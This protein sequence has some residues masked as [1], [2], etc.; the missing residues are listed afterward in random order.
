[1]RES[2]FV[3]VPPEDVLGFMEDRCRAKCGG[4]AYGSG[5]KLVGFWKVYGDVDAAK[6]RFRQYDKCRSV[7]DEKWRLGSSIEKLTVKLR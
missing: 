3:H 6:K 7:Y 4:C 5:C 2:A 1:M